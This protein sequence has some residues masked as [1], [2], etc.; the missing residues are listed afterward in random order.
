MITTKV[1][2]FKEDLVIDGNDLKELNI[3]EIKP[4]EWIL[5]G[6]TSD[7]LKFLM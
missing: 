3:N 6:D 2:L 5:I 1:P 4:G 7:V